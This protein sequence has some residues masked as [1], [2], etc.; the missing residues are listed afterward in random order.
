MRTGIVRGTN[1]SQNE[2]QKWRKCRKW[3]ARDEMSG[4]GARCSRLAD[5][6]LGTNRTVPHTHTHTRQQDLSLDSLPYFAHFGSVVIEIYRTHSNNVRESEHNNKAKVWKDAN[7][8]IRKSNG[9]LADKMEYERK[10]NKRQKGNERQKKMSELASGRGVQ[11][12]D[13]QFAFN[14]I[15]SRDL[16]WWQPG[17][18]HLSIYNRPD[19]I[20]PKCRVK[21]IDTPPSIAMWH[22]FTLISKSYTYNTYWRF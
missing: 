7:R 9:I 3:P 1:R 17:L 13:M 15:R 18:L 22:A 5:A 2:E 14:L 16:E 21:R 12:L 4:G 6:S 20:W 19:S 8:F 11:D 10:G